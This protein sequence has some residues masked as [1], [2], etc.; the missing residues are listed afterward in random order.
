M[1][2][3]DYIITGWVIEGSGFVAIG[4]VVFSLPVMFK[5]DEAL[6]KIDEACEIHI[7]INGFEIS[8]DWSKKLKR[9]WRLP[10]SI[11]RRQLQWSLA[12]LLLVV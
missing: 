3:M 4:S 8:T 5:I 11:L 12:I 7:G 6:K 9:E 1:V 10:H 2:C